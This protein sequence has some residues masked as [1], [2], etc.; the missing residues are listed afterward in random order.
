MTISS[1]ESGASPPAAPPSQRSACVYCGSARGSDPAFAETT[2]ALG[3]AFAANGIRL[4]YGGGRVGLMGVVADA[5]MDAGGEV[6]GIIPQHI[7]E[8]ELQHSGLT[9]LFVVDT[10]HTRKR[11]MADRSQAFVILPGGFGTLDEC[12]EIITWK[13][14]GL[15]ESPVIFLN[16]HGFWDRLVALV[17]HQTEA[18][19][20]S[21][22]RRRMFMVVDTVDE[23]IAELLKLPILT[24]PPIEPDIR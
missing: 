19:F 1:N 3:Q 7:H 2:I 13:Q 4:I 8:R 15:H 16:V 9:E 21:A 11:M 20:I 14:L 10:M 22:N 24:T 12:F 6:T 5:T 23:V 18:G 17:D